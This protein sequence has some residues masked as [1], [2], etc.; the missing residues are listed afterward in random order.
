MSKFVQAKGLASAETSV[1]TLAKMDA[2]VDGVYAELVTV[3]KRGGLNGIELIQGLVLAT[4]EWTPE[5]VH[6]AEGLR[7]ILELF[8]C[9]EKAESEE[10]FGYL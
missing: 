8:N 1:E 5:N 7:L 3:G 4:E 9:C 10:D 2:V 6:F